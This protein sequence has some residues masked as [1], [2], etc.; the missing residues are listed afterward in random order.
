M[1]VDNIWI[2]ETRD[3]TVVVAVVVAHT[4]IW[5]PVA[6]ARIDIAQLEQ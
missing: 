5:L 6:F 1:A 4:L 2:G 3:W